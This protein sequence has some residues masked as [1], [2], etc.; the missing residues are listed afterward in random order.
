M[1]RNAKSHLPLGVQLPILHIA[2]AFVALLIPAIGNGQSANLPTLEILHSFAGG[3]DGQNPA[4]GLIHDSAGNLYGV[5][6]GIRPSNEGTIFK[7]TPTG[8]ETV[9]YTFLGAPQSPS[10]PLA[11]D[12]VGNL[13]TAT[14]LGGFGGF[15]SVFKLATSGKGSVLYSFLGGSDGANPQ[16]ALVLDATGNLYGTTIQGGGTGCSSYGCGTVFRINPDGSETVLHRFT[17]PP[18]GANPES[19]VIRDA[20]GNLYGTTYFGGAHNLGTV[21][22]VSSTGQELVLYSFGGKDGFGPWGRLYRDGAGNLFGTTV[23]GGR[24]TVCNTCGTVFELLANGN[25]V[26]LHN[27]NGQSDGYFPLG[28]LV[29]DRLGNFYGTTA[30]GDGYGT[31]FKIGA[32]G[33][34]TT[35]HSFGRADGANPY[36][37]LVVDGSGNLYG[38]TE[39]G[40]ANKLGEVFKLKP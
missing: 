9:L 10:G 1:N 6:Q 18:D 25:E 8:Q 11:R 26:V 36:C 39:A 32:D 16:G 34:F 23:Q 27:F 4:V 28:D 12:G 7:I 29:R 31:I 2:V 5:A 14:T 17:G 13:Y 35:L 3:A 19:G 33:T 38:T 24:S 40:G 15:G 22:E 37:G 30:D 21:F 20:Q